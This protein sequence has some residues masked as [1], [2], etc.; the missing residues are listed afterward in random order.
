MA[1]ELMERLD[2]ILQYQTATQLPPKCSEIEMAALVPL[3]REGYE[4]YSEITWLLNHGRSGATLLSCEEFLPRLHEQYNSCHKF[5]TRYRKIHWLVATTKIPEIER[6]KPAFAQPDTSPSTR[7][8]ELEMEVR[9]LE[10]QRASDQELLR[11]YENVCLHSN[12]FGM[13]NGN[14][15]NLH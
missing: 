15:F 8:K 11:I 3:I 6:Y 1:F 10:S 7:I 5:F 12:V 13:L 2:E 9:A 4:I 14:L